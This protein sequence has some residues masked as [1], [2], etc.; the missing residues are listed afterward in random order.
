MAKDESVYRLVGIYSKKPERKVYSRFQLAM[1]LA[2]W[3]GDRIHASF[4]IERAAIGE[5][6]D[7]TE[8]FLNG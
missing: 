4:R 3:G 1:K 2:S 6:S 5:W 7:V 8:E